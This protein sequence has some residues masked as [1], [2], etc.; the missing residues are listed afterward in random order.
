MNKKEKS[1]SLYCNWNIYID[2]EGNT[3]LP[4][5]H[6]QYIKGLKNI[7]FKKIILLSKVSNKKGKEHDFYFQKKELEVIPISYFKS[8][9]TS[10]IKIKSI[11]KTFYLSA[12]KKTDYC[13]IRTYEPFI[14][15]LVL[16]QK[17]FSRKTILCMHYISEPKSAI[18]SNITSSYAKKLFR[19]FLFLPEYY[20]TNIASVFCKVSSNGPVPIKNTPFF[21][22]RRILEVIES[23]IL[24][25]D[26]KKLENKINY[27]NKSS[28]ASIL[29]V[30]YIRPSKGI[31]ALINTVELL[32]EDNIVNFKITIIGTGEYLASIK[33]SIKNKNLVQYFEFKGYIPFSDKLFYEYIRSDIF[34]NLSPSETGP[35]VLLE[36]GI[37]D[38]FLI[39]TKVGYASRIIKKNGILIDINNN[40]QAKDALK[41][42]ISFTMTKKNKNINKDL[43]KHTTENFFRNILNNK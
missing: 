21:V 36:A 22:R 17:I 4:S 33:E 27:D 5:V 20:L 14:W 18:F 42:A 25:S 9:L 41:E 3:W 28:I 35:R 8:Y 34:I 43:S 11:I 37:F 38:C 1:I 2:S 32:L 15:L 39:S 23:A 40:I 31:N 30:G 13:Y 24:E 7:N 19:Y 6:A 26:L 12:R 29:Y 16:M 10:L